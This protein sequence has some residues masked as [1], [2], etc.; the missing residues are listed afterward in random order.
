M[1]D[2]RFLRYNTAN[3][4]QGFSLLEI[5]LALVILGFVVGGVL[6][7]T[8]IIRASA[9]RQVIKERLYYES[10]I[11]NFELAYRA[12]PGDM[13]FAF[14]RWGATCG[15]NDAVISTGCNGNGDG[16]IN[17]LDGENIKAWEH[18]AR[19]EI[20]EGTYPGSGSLDA[21]SVYVLPTATNSPASKLSGGIWGLADDVS[22]I[23]AGTVPDS[24]LFLILGSATEKS[25]PYFSNIQLSRADA[26]S[27]DEKMDEGTASRG[28]TRGPKSSASTGCVDSGIDAYGATAAADMQDC[29]IT[30]T[31]QQ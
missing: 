6:V 14:D 26:R 27:I 9:L 18:M 20:I 4:L 24:Q 23:I 11:T 15:T 19:A 29:Y 31:L 8:D 7:G 10:S 2:T 25:F 30:F 21:S 17:A 16:V 22:G 3:K 28:F 5:S 12:L 13:E 1:N